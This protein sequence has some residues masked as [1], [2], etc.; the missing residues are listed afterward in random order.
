M[1][2]TEGS[3]PLANQTVDIWLV[4]TPNLLYWRETLALTQRK[5]AK[6]LG[7]SLRAYTYYEHGER[8]IPI[9]VL[10]AC[11]YMIT[12]PRAALRTSKLLTA[13]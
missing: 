13:A 1:P 2:K 8:H 4:T 10:L 7:L 12:Y 6:K 5:A 11:Q 9:P 3:G